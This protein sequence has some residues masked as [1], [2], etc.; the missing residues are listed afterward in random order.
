MEGNR[1]SDDEKKARV[2][3]P[4]SKVNSPMRVVWGAIYT[5]TSS[6]PMF[7]T[8]DCTAVGMALTIS[9]LRKARRI[10]IRYRR[11]KATASMLWLGSVA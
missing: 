10:S 8:L 3:N 5:F 11:L 1:R 7:N 6:I 4:F 9:G 2:V